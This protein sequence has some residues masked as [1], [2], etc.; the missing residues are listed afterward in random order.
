M[1]AVRL[2]AGVGREKLAYLDRVPLLLARIQ[3]PGVA[4]RCTKEFD[5]TDPAR[6]DFISEHFLAPGST[7]RSQID[8]YILDGS[9]GKHLEREIQG[10]RDIPLH[11]VICEAPHAAANRVGM[12]S[13]RSRWPWLASSIRLDQNLG[14]AR[15]LPARTGL[16]LQL[17][18][19]TWKSVLQSSQKKL[20]CSR[21]VMN[22]HYMHS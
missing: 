19:N 20:Y 4:V 11:D 9:L 7:L 2:V 10:L 3:E 8:R 18:W 16:D 1:G 14:D 22:R 21:M 15:S 17:T 13:R 12:V 6:R 5:A